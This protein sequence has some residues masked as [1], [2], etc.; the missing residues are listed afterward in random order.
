V[1]YAST[2]YTDPHN[3]GSPDCRDT[4]HNLPHSRDSCKITR[5]PTHITCFLQVGPHLSSSLKYLPRDLYRAPQLAIH[6]AT[7]SLDSHRRR[8]FIRTPSDICKHPPQQIT[9]LSQQLTI[10]DK[11]SPDRPWQPCSPTYPPSVYPGNAPLAWR[12]TRRA[13]PARGRTDKAT[14]S[15][16][17]ASAA[18]SNWP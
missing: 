9:K 8:I 5:R 12:T 11:S 2:L 1:S 6:L 7:S 4:A 16:T 14:S 17:P 15:A 18:N 10:S 3:R 13:L